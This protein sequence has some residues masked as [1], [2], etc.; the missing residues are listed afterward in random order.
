MKKKGFS[1]VEL[2]FVMVVMG[3]LLAMAQPSIQ[4]SINTSRAIDIK[5]FANII[6]SQQNKYF[7]ENAE[8]DTVNRTK[9]ITSDKIISSNDIHYLLKN[10]MYLTTNSQRCSDGMLG[11]YIKVEDP[12]L[13]SSSLKNYVEYDSCLQTKVTRPIL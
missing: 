5:E 12:I 2:M 8:F 11:M 6:V 9:V 10:G 1:I 4:N 13:Q 7:E 3:V